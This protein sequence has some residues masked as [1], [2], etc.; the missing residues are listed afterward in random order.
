MRGIPR[1]VDSEGR[2]VIPASFRKMFEIE[3]GDRLVWTIDNGTLNIRIVEED[4]I[5]KEDIDNDTKSDKER[6]SV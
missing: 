5:S 6:R 3:T 4:S 2:I 1:P